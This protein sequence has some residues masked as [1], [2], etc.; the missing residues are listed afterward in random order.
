MSICGVLHMPKR[1]RAGMMDAWGVLAS[2]IND[3][4]DI[5][6]YLIFLNIL[7][8]IS[9]S[10][11]I[12]A[13]PATVAL[14]AITRELGYRRPVTWRDFVRMLFQYFFIGWRWGF[15]NLI[16]IAIIVINFVFYQ[17]LDPPI[18]FLGRGIWM[19]LLFFW[20]LVQMYCLPIMMEQQQS[21]IRLAL[22]NSIV[23]VLRHPF[24]SIVF[25]L[26][27]TAFIVASIMVTYFWFCFTVALLCYFYNRG[28]WYL[29]RI[30]NGEEPTLE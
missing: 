29:T 6:V 24:Y 28:V 30:E 5:G 27:A 2:A 21:S 14:F 22:R 4:R 18:D 20:F 11:L 1:R 12:T 3:V 25:A 9:S 15:V 23:L 17:T 26:V 19:I 10:L 16:V 8:F 13:P 7:W